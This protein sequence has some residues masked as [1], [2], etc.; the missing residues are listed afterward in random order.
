M[1]L[2]ISASS[3]NTKYTI[4]LLS[5]YHELFLLVDGIFIPFSFAFFSSILKTSISLFSI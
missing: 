1:L 2:G 4:P 3:S 5:K